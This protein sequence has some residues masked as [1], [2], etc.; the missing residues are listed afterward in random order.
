ME[1]TG[2][3]EWDDAAEPFVIDRVC[4][5]PSDVDMVRR[6]MLEMFD[7]WGDKISWNMTQLVCEL[8]AG[9]SDL[10]LAVA[11][12]ELPPAERELLYDQA[13]NAA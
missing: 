11:I 6:L 1:R 3:C 7:T 9:I 2:S 12:D 13:L 10:D 8:P 4:T 5:Q